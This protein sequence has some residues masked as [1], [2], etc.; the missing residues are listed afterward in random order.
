VALLAPKKA[1]KSPLSILFMMAEIT[2]PG[3]APQVASSE[4]SKTWGNGVADE[5]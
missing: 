5:V 2:E 1:E 3:S 4:K